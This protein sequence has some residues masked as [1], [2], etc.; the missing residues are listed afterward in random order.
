MNG[1]ALLDALQQRRGTLSDGT[2]AVVL[3]AVDVIDRSIAAIDGA[4]EQHPD[5]TGLVRRLAMAY[6]QEIQLLQRATRL[7][8]ET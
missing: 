2:V 1:A 7:P 8:D 5:D 6:R 4:L 3:D